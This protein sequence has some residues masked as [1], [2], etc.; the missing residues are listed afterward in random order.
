METLEEGF[1]R[2]PREGFLSHYE[3]MKV[4]SKEFSTQ[5]PT[6]AIVN[7]EEGAFRPGFVLS[8]LWFHDV[9]DNGDT[10]LIITSNETLISVGSICSNYPV[11]SQ[12]TFRGLMIWHNYPGTRL[13][14]KFS[15]V[16]LIAAAITT[17]TLDGSVFVEHLVHVE[18]REALNLGV[19][20]RLRVQ[21][22]LNTDIFL[23]LLKKGPKVQLGVRVRTDDRGGLRGFL[24]IL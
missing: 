8:M 11:S 1:L 7:P 12:T 21:L 10:V 24:H 5:M 3:V 2:V 14:R 15:G 18:R 22:L 17:V 16:I 19:D 9:Q 23:I 4:V 6:M 20:A 13:Q